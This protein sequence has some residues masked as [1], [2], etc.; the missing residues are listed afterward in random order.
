MVVAALV[1]AAL[2]DAELE[3]LVEELEALEALDEAE[4]DA[5]ELAALLDED[6]E[7][8]ASTSAASAN[9]AANAT[10]NFTFFI[11]PSLSAPAG[12]PSRLL[13]IGASSLYCNK[14]FGS[15]PHPCRHESVQHE[16]EAS[17][18]RTA[19]GKPPRPGR[20]GITGDHADHASANRH[21]VRRL[22]SRTNGPMIF[23][24]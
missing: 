14:A 19:R 2:L 11:F 6:D 9:A 4:A 12:R 15:I 16:R 3:A 1:L 7:Q 18:R 21:H 20:G 13:L 23:T 10:M 17:R 8:P 24:G 22:S 5:D